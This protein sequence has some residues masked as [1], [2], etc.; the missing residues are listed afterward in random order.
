MRH[1]L[2]SLALIGLLSSCNLQ[3]RKYLKGYYFDKQNK[4]AHNEKAIESAKDVIKHKQQIITAS[5][6]QTLETYSAKETK[7]QQEKT[8]DTLLLKDGVKMLVRISDVNKNQIHYYLCESDNQAEFIIETNKVSSLHYANGLNDNLNNPKDAPY[9]YSEYPNGPKYSKKELDNATEMVEE[10]R[11]LIFPGF[12]WGYQL[13]FQRYRGYALAL[14]ARKILRDQKGY[15]SYYR[16]T[17]WLLLPMWISLI[18]L[19]LLA[20]LLALVYIFG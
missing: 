14:K 16:Q 12:S 18:T 5:I 9:D 15:E 2:F 17:F 19:G 10:A 6:P 13:P 8:C 11:Q 1:L 7:V 3:K 20:V 4:V